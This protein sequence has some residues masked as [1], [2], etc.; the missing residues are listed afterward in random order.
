MPVGVVIELRGFE[1]Q[2]IRSERFILAL[3]ILPLLFVGTEAEALQF[4]GDMRMQPLLRR[5]Q[6]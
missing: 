1:G 4:N 3:E 6:P 2:R 5:P